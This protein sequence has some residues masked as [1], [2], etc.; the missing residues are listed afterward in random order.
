MTLACFLFGIAG[1]ARSAGK[2]CETLR[3]A[4][5]MRKAVDEL[6]F[7]NLIGLLFLPLMAHFAWLGVGVLGLARRRSGSAVA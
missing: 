4:E 1:G 6:V 7:A 2:A 3:P 5:T